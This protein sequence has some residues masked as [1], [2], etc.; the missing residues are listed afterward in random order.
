MYCDW[1]KWATSFSERKYAAVAI[2]T[3]GVCACFLRSLGVWA[4][5]ALKAVVSV[6]SLV[7][8]VREVN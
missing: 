5:E 2:C 3:D 4:E 7:S 1:C 6:V 8:V